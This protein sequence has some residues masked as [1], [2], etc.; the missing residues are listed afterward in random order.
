MLIDINTMS[1]VY[2]ETLCLLNI[3]LLVET[4]ST[5]GLEILKIY[6]SKVQANYKL[7]TFLF[8]LSLD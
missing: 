8:L 2:Y 5:F 3:W 6:S 1:K 4:R 7:Y